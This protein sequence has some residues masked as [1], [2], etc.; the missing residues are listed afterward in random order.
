MFNRR[1]G[2]RPLEGAQVEN[3]EKHQ[4]PHLCYHCHVLISL[5]S[6]DS[7]RVRDRVPT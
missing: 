3:L 5:L 4:K 6:T 2:V 1:F 7:I